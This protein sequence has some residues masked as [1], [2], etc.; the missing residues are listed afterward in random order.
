LAKLFLAVGSIVLSNI[1]APDKTDRKD[2]VIKTF[3]SSG[4]SFVAER[5]NRREFSFRVAPSRDAIYQIIRESE[6]TG[7]V[8]VC[9]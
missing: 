6:E 8:C 1:M 5:R 2:F 9:V 7:S 3:Y 4:G